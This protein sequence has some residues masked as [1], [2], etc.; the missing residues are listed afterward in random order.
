MWADADLCINGKR[1]I[2]K[3]KACWYR[4]GLYHTL[5]LS[6]THPPIHPSFLT[7]FILYVTS[8]AG[9]GRAYTL[10]RSQVH[11][12][13]HTPSH[14]CLGVILT[15]L[16]NVTSMFLDSEKKTGVSGETQTCKPPKYCVT[17]L[18]T[19]IKE[20]GIICQHKTCNLI[21]FEDLWSYVLSLN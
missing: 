7:R 19:R 15:P 17:L 1:N 14:S 6:G 5:L 13:P 11:C 3:V 10:D 8:V 18:Q 4:G 20:H 21:N 16:L 9:V 2:N 12:R